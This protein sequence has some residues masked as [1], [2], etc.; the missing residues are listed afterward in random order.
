M[1]IRFTG[2][3]GD[4][5]YPRKYQIRFF[6]TLFLMM[7]SLPFRIRFNRKHE[8]LFYDTILNP[9]SLRKRR[10]FL[11]KYVH[12]AGG[13]AA[14]L[15]FDGNST[16]PKLYVNGLSFAKLW[17]FH[18]A[19]STFVRAAFLDMFKPNRIHWMWRLALVNKTFQQI[20]WHSP[21][22]SQYQ[23]FSYEPST[24]LSALMAGRYLKGYT[25]ATISSNSVQFSNNRYHWNPKLAYKLCSRFQEAETQHYIN[26]GWMNIGS[27]DTW[28]LEEEVYIDQVEQ[29]APTYDIGIYSGAFW[30]RTHDLWRSGDLDALRGYAYNDNPVYLAY[31]PVLQAIIDLKQQY[32]LKVKVYFHPYEFSLMEDHG[33]DPPYLEIL[34]ANGI[35]WEQD[36]KTSWDNFY[37]P[38]VGVAML[39]TI[40]FDRLHYGLPSYFYSG[41]GVSSYNLDL[42]YLS[43][44]ADYVYQSPDHLVQ[45]LKMELSL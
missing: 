1:V 6:F 41:E 36:G 17:A 13:E 28:G 9:E 34:T 4:T 29:T 32:D 31:M 14:I 44:C 23:F 12:N 18:R 7:W 8:V 21:K 39:S 19:G 2:K 5:P 26:F 16:F 42:K 35:D 10:Y 45:Q 22:H 40:V 33:I 24:Y 11:H 3:K 38:K 27:R 25:P 30:A 43:S 15:G 37:E 20:L